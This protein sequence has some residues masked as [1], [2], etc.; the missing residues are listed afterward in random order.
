MVQKGLVLGILLLMIFSLLPVMTVGYHTT[1]TFKETYRVASE[2]SIV[3]NKGSQDISG[4]PPMDSPWPMKCHDNHHTGRSPYSTAD[5][6]L[7][8]EK[9][10]FET[11]GGIVD[12]PTIDNEGVIYFGESWDLFAVYP[13]GTLKWSYR[14]N[15]IIRG[16]SP[17]IDENGIIYVG[18]W[19][20][21]LYALYSNG[22]KKWRFG[23]GDSIASSPAIAA[24]G[25]IYF[26][27]MGNKI[28]ALH[29]NGT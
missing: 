9:W 12:G 22:T 19:D 26:G 18:S 11:D 1:L 15:G 28:F 10:R 13:N 2:K 29:P 6:P 23:A 4:S 8:V 21:G 14:T 7:G 16:S 24:D 5:N 27:T 25:T 17:A 20:A 3:P